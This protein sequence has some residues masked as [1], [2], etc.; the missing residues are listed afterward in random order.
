M[1]GVFFGGGEG[2]EAISHLEEEV[3]INQQGGGEMSREGGSHPL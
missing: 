3:A 2:G 1:E